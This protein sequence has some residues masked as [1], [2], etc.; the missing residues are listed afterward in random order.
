MVLYPSIE[1]DWESST[2]SL[3]LHANLC[4]NI[5]ISHNKGKE[6]L[7]NQGRDFHKFSSELSFIIILHMYEM[8]PRIPKDQDIDKLVTEYFGNF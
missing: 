6:E 2:F 4:I 3:L 1:R 5:I 8:L 7:H